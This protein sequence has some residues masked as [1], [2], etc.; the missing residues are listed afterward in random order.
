MTRPLFRAVGGAA[1]A[2]V[3][4]A[5]MTTPVWA[6]SVTYNGN[7]AMLQ[8]ITNTGGTPDPVENSVAPSDSGSGRSPN[9][10]GNSV[11]VNGGGTAPDFVFGAVNIGPDS[12]LQAVT[13]N[14]VIINNATVNNWVIGGWGTT[15]T[16][17]SVALN[18]SEVDAVAG[19]YS[20][21][22]SGS[23]TVTATDNKVTIGDGNSGSVVRRGVYGGYAQVNDGDGA[24]TATGNSVT[25]NDG[26]MGD[27]Y[28]GYAAGISGAATATNNSVTVND[29]SMGDVYGG[30]ADTDLVFDDIAG[31]YVNVGGD[32]NA[33]ASNNRVS[34]K[35]GNMGDVYGGFAETVSGNATASGNSVTVS[36]LSIVRGNIY[37]GKASATAAS[38]FDDNVGD[39]VAVGGDGNATASNN[40]VAVSDTVRVMNNISG[41][42]ASSDSGTATATNNSVA[43]SGGAQVAGGVT[44]GVASVSDGGGTATAT[45]NKV[46]ISGNAQTGQVTGGVASVSNG[47]GTAMA[48]GNSV[49]ISG[50]SAVHGA[51][52]GG[53]ANLDGAGMSGT[54]NNN[55]VTIS[56][57]STVVGSVYGGFSQ[58][59]GH[60]ETGSATGN[61]VTIG[62]A[63]DL[64]GASLYG[65]F[66]GSGAIL[67]PGTD[68]F[69]GNTLN[70]L[71]YSGSSVQS[72]QNF[73]YY[74]FIFPVAQNTPVLTVTG[75]AVLDDGNGK[76]SI[77]TASTF[78]GTAPLRPG[79]S[80]ILIQAGSLDAAG[81]TQTQAQGLHGA[82]LSYLWNLDPA[83]DMLTATVARVQATPQAKVL[84]EGFLSGLALVNQGADLVAGQGMS[85]A[86]QASLETKSGLGVFGTLG[87]GWS[88]YDTGSN[89]EMSSVSLLAGLSRGTDLRSG[90]L[91]LG[92]FFEYGTGSYDTNNAFSGI[93]AFNGSG[94]VDHVGGGIL[95]R[96]D[97]ADAGQGHVYAEGSFRA[98][99]VSNDYS[100][101]NL[102]DVMGKSANG[103]NSDSAYYGLHAGL[104][105]IWNLDDNISL[106]LYGKYFWTRV[107]GDDVTLATG[108]SITFNS[109]D[110][111]RVRI[112]SR[113]AYAEDE[114]FTPYVGVAY[115]H[116]FDGKA[117]AT[118]SGYAIDAPDLA[119]GT[120]I[121]EVGMRIKPDDD[122][123]LS[124]NLGMQGYVGTRQGVTGSVQMKFEF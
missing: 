2:F 22:A 67:A 44:G 89:V 99:S 115:E 33:T 19:G 34:V 64:S 60:G 3:L 87:G 92:A 29:G 110:S 94:D 120:G 68:A 108:E 121:G 78:G 31:H 65:G 52:Y 76:S 71:N 30:Y 42:Y 100:N 46:T 123:P 48:T 88:R 16:G 118:T 32:G 107:Q 82:T 80:V 74:N 122:L 49:A 90:R 72:V 70:V 5:S 96:M 20:S 37:G 47:G 36:G 27:V 35:G 7:P 40:S 24:A 84:S 109:A 113:F 66:V 21:L 124:I 101:F 62:G 9:F 103:Y 28:G 55:Q 119:G 79:T 23:A 13:K 69:T 41:G 51:V 56:G 61:T 12:D 11:T 38:G 81:F 114:S 39:Y 15:V 1:P 86:M 102:R 10:S 8:S 98:G 6:D 75:P 73:Q 14:Q 53:Y 111:N 59:D 17:N 91:T 105:Y 77:I 117:R 85:D 57:I 4:L 104:G 54:A 83:G 97:F 63:P 43:I 58:V 18:G 95:G 26:N 112:G 106:D 116:E 45:N 93:G 50:N 25:V